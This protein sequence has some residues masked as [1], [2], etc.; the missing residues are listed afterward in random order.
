MPM[1]RL[2][3][4]LGKIAEEA[5]EVAQRALKA[6]QFG[7]DEIQDG[8]DCTNAQRLRGELIDLRAVVEMVEEEA[9]VRLLAVGIES[10]GTEPFAIT[11]KKKKVERYIELSRS[12]GQ[13][14]NDYGDIGD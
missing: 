14:T 8:Q 6:Q 3:L 7:L 1:T 5:A 2:Q 10:L 9:E 11:E 12:L 13:V 4:L